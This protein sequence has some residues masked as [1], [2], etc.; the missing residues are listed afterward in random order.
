MRQGQ[1]G[2]SEWEKA[3]ARKFA[4]EQRELSA[5]IMNEDEEDR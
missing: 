3:Q 1:A 2:V 4:E 5:N